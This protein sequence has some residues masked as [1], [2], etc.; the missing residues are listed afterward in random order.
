MD[1]VT[2]KP[3]EICNASASAFPDRDGGFSIHFVPAG[4]YGVVYRVFGQG[5]AQETWLEGTV[6]LK[7]GEQLSGIVIKVK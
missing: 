3:G 5:P 4:E 7:D 1:R 6:N 2:A